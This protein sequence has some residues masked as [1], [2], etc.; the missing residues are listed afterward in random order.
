MTPLRNRDRLRQVFSHR[1][2]GSRSDKLPA[3]SA[4]STSQLNAAGQSTTTQQDFQGRVFLLLSQQDQDTIRQHTLLN[5]T[6]LNDVVRQAVTATR[7]KQAICQSKRW[8]F[9][10]RG[11]TVVLRDKADNVVKWLDRF[12]KIGD[13]ASN[14]DPVHFGLPWAGIRV[15]LE[16]SLTERA[17]SVTSLWKCVLC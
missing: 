6:D 10:F 8:T 1:S 4:T 5:A 13:V 12:K 16:V 14:A 9:T 11:H 7:Q 17:H 2:N 3:P 15:L